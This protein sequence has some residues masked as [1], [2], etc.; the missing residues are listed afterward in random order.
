MQTVVR[1]RVDGAVITLVPG[2]ESARTII[3]LEILH[4]RA[5]PVDGDAC[6]I[7][8]FLAAKLI[9]VPYHA[10]EFTRNALFGPP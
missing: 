9:E 1:S 10:F 2:A 3:L 8:L 7:E 6:F 4:A 5:H